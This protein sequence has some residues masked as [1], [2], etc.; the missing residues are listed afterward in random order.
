MNVAGDLL[1]HEH[2]PVFVHVRLGLP[3]VCFGAAARSQNLSGEPLQR[4]AVAV[5]VNVEPGHS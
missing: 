5:E 4:L 1:F 3:V 2:F